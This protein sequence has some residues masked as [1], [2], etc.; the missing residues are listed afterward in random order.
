MTQSWRLV[1]RYLR[2]WPLSGSVVVASIG[3]VYTVS[4][5]KETHPEVH[6]VLFRDTGV[7]VDFVGLSTATSEV[8]EVV[9]GVEH[10]VIPIEISSASHPF[11]TGEENII[12]SAGRVE[13]FKA[14]AGRKS[15]TGKRQ[16][17][18]VAPKKK[19]TEDVLAS[20]RNQQPS[21]SKKVTE[22]KVAPQRGEHQQ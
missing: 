3:M 16:R 1:R 22:K 7:G 17:E 15:V 11:Y 8:K 5:K 21:V 9:D 12:D 18:V 6:P 19:E 4:M 2:H 20:K 13:K 14:R 10:F